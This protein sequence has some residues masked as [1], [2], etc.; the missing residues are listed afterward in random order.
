[1]LRPHNTSKNPFPFGGFQRA[2]RHA[3]DTAA[4]NQFLAQRRRPSG[5]LKYARRYLN[6]VQ[7]EVFDRLTSLQRARLLALLVHRLSGG[8]V[9]PLHPECFELHSRDR[10]RWFG[11]AWRSV[12]AAFLIKAPGSFVRGR[13]T[14]PYQARTP[15][16]V[17]TIEEVEHLLEVAGYG[18]CLVE[19]AQPIHRGP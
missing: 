2:A 12:R 8:H 5:P 3:D 7:R 19:V 14:L 1:M 17:D 15:W 9:H 11:K 6:E 18:R 4:L 16:T 10:Q 13:A